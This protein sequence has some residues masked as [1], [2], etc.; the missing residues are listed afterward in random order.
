MANPGPNQQTSTNLQP[1]LGSFDNS[2]NLLQAY[3]PNNVALVLNG[4]TATTGGTIDGTV[5]GA[6][7]PS[8][9]SFTQV[10]RTIGA[11]ITA[12]TYTVGV[13]DTHLIFNNA[14][15]TCTVTLPTASAANKGRELVLRTTAAFTVVSAGS[16][17]VPAIGGSATTAILAATAGKWA[18]LVSDGTAWQIQMSN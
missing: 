16:N 5:I 12:N 7:T 8:Q 14:S 10:E 1:I 13:A 15:Q 2:G 3:G 17:V 9:G 4:T 18:C 11:A 6:T